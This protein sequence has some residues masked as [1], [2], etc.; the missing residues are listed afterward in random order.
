CILSALTSSLLFLMSHAPTETHTL[1][2]HDALPI[3]TTSLPGISSR[4]NAPV[5]SITRLE[6]GKLGIS[7]GADP[8]AIMQF[9]YVYVCDCLSSIAFTCVSSTTYSSP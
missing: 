6:N 1:S 9:L 5:E 3:L 7:I 2:L 8:V 4:S